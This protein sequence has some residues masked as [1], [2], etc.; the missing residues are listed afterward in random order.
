MI[1]ELERDWG[2]WRQTF[3]GIKTGTECAENIIWIIEQLF[4]LEVWPIMTIHKRKLKGR[5]DVE[6]GETRRTLKLLFISIP[7]NYFSLER[8]YLFTFS[9]S[10]SA[11][12]ISNL[13]KRQ[14]VFTHVA[15]G[16][17]N[18]WNKLLNWKT[19]LTPTSLVND[20]DMPRLYCFTTPTWRTWRHMKRV[21]CGS[22]ITK[23]LAQYC[24]KRIVV[25]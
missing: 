12:S 13:L 23:Q 3:T 16:Y 9:N 25:S 24:Y 21:H 22:I 10:T 1:K 15:S 19:S 4:L 20:T 11:S 6:R 8:F 14:S 7:T 5:N 18:F 2:I 17:A